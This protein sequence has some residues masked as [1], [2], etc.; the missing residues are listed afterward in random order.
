MGFGLYLV[1]DRAQTRGRPLLDVI[2]M[3]LEGGAEAVQLRERDLSDLE[4]YRLADQTRRL[5]DDFGAALLINDRIDVALGVDAQ[6]IHLGGHSFP[7]R[8]ARR[9][10]GMGRI[11]GAS[12]HSVL[13]ARMA[14]AEGADFV[15]FGPVHHTPSKARYGEP[16]GEERMHEAAAAVRIPLLAIGGVNAASVPRLLAS[17]ARGVAV[18]S[19]IHAADDPREATRE[20]VRSLE[21]GPYGRHKPN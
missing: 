7:I 16:V 18:I 17:G 6:G 4:L 12:T 15:V 5:C 10:L 2:K 14:E 9:L 13:E 3:A 1:T 19:A 20:F 21:T 8:E 11:I